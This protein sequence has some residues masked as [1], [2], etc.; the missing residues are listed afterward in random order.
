MA[1][2]FWPYSEKL[3]ITRKRPKNCGRDSTEKPNANNKK[4]QRLAKNKKNSRKIELQKKKN[5]NVRARKSIGMN[6]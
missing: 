6:T 3:T 5:W 1:G 2:R 4:R